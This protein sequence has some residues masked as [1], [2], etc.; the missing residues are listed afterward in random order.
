MLSCRIHKTELAA[1]EEK[2]LN[3]YE[4][5]CAS[6]V[7]E[8]VY[9][10]ECDYGEIKG[11]QGQVCGEDDSHQQH[12]STTNFNKYEKSMQITQQSDEPEYVNIIKMKAC[13]N[14]NQIQDTSHQQ[15]MLPH[16]NEVVVDK[17]K[18]QPSAPL[19]EPQM[20]RE[21]EGTCD[22]DEEVYDDTQPYQPRGKGQHD[23]YH[24]EKKAA[25]VMGSTVKKIDHNEQEFNDCDYTAIPQSSAAG[26]TTGYQPLLGRDGDYENNLEDYN[27]INESQQLDRSGA[28]EEYEYV[29]TKPRYCYRPSVK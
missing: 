19:A 2:E 9:V 11:Q 16:N 3:R 24:S 22:I 26:C 20:P 27:S 15:S 5:L 4:N 25:V 14:A 12:H 7:Q 1:Q 29:V 17:Y 10:E 18:T 13:P 8:G 6:R 21:F 23:Q 28:N